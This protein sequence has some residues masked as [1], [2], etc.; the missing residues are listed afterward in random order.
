[1]LILLHFFLR[2]ADN[3]I[4]GEGKHSIGR[5]EAGPDIVGE[6]H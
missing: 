2:T 1:M 3:R 4:C 5:S 6:G